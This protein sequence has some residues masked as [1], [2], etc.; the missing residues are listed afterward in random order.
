MHMETLKRIITLN[1]RKIYQVTVPHFAGTDSSAEFNKLSGELNLRISREM[2][3]MMN[4]VSA[5]FQRVINDA[6]SSQVLPQIQNVLK[7]GSGPLTQKGCNIPT[8][9]PERQQEHHPSQRV[10][11]NYRG[12]PVRIRPCDKNTVNAY[13]MVRGDNESPILLP[14][15]LTGRMPSRTHLNQSHDDLKPLLDTTIP[16]QVEPHRLQN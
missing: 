14:W 7:A 15:F 4:N 6:I 3:E 5:Q 11:S 13:D 16:A 12:E 10:R 1:L 9:R 2:D 8:K